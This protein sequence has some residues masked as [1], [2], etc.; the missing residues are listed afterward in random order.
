MTLEPMEGITPQAVA[1]VL[2]VP[3]SYEDSACQCWAWGEGEK[4]VNVLK[5]KGKQTE[6]TEVLQHFLEQAEYSVGVYS[7]FK[8][9]HMLYHECCG[10]RQQQ[11]LMTWFS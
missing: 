8:G 11:V 7:Q 4:G 3:A 2:S 10:L 6:Y 9:Q 1:T 5:R